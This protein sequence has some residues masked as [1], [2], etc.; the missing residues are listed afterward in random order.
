VLVSL[1]S[2]VTLPASYYRA[3]DVAW[4]RLAAR[5]F[6]IDEHPRVLLVAAKGP[7]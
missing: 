2:K 5:V 7:G 6:V 3:V 4:D 1:P